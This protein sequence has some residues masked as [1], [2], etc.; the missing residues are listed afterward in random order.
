MACEHPIIHLPGYTHSMVP[1]S[2]QAVEGFHG[3][4]AVVGVL[5]VGEGFVVGDN[6]KIVVAWG[7]SMGPS[8]YVFILCSRRF[9]SAR[10]NLFFIVS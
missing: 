9:Y 8:P 5:V 7:P 10:D 4:E 3:V 6:K 1:S 2:V